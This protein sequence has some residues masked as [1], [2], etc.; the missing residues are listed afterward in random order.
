MS[1]ETLWYA[2][3]VVYGSLNSVRG[4]S[5]EKQFKAKVQGQLEEGSMFDV[6]RSK[7]KKTARTSDLQR[8]TSNLELR[9]LLP[10]GAAPPLNDSSEVWLRATYNSSNESLVPPRITIVAWFVQR[11][12]ARI[13]YLHE[14]VQDQ[15]NNG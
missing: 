6:R 13:G 9:T 5:L 15:P 1:A 2:T 7:L 11:W 12:R 14:Q 10:V 8:R 4:S 3:F